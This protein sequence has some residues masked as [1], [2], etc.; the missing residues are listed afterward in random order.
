MITKIIKKIWQISKMIN[1][2]FIY[3]FFLTKKNN[4]NNWHLY[5]TLN[6]RPYKK[7]I[8]NFCNKKNFQNVLDYGCGFGEIIKELKSKKKYAYDTDQN[9]IKISHQLF[10]SYNINFLHEKDLNSFRKNKIDCVLFI[11]FLH[12]Y[13]EEKVKEI[14][15][16]FLVS[17]YILLDAIKPGVKGYKYF[18]NYDFM[19]EKFQIQKKIFRDEPNRFF[20]ILKKKI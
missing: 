8:I 10:N 4:I 16:P 5:N 17:N 2:K 9:I 19:K 14:I 6:N 12:D 11:N 1:I 20:F 18:H 3:Y 15:Y 7:E 13:N